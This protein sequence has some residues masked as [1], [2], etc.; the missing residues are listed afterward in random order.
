MHHTHTRTPVV[1][2]HSRSKAAAPIW[3]SSRTSIL[4]FNSQPLEGGCD[5]GCRHACVLLRFNSQPLEGGCSASSAVPRG[6]DMFQLTAARRRLRRLNFDWHTGI[7]FQLTAARRRLLLIMPIRSSRLTFQ[8][9]A[10]RRRLPQRRRQR[11]EIFK[12]STHSRSKAAAQGEEEGCIPIPGFNSQPLEGGCRCR[13]LR[14]TSDS[15]FNS[16][17]LEGGC[18]VVW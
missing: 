15:G 1:S 4:G 2:T 10:A 11:G 7:R 9:T 5:F 6:T 13:R 16:Q 3:P 12:V 18:P 17:P 8:L 14:S